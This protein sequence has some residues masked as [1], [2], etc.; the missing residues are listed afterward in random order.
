MKFCAVCSA[1]SWAASGAERAPARVLGPQAA[2]A[3]GDIL[4]AESI[5]RTEVTGMALVLTG[6]GL[7]SRKPEAMVNPESAVKPQP[8]VK[9][10]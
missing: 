7:L 5:T 8:A 4:L 10:N 9:G 1:Q 3:P 2:L 6:A